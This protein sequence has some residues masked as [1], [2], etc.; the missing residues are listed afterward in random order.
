MHARNLFKALKEIALSEGIV[1]SPQIRTEKLEKILKEALRSRGYFCLFGIVK[2]FRSLMIWKKEKRR[3]FSV[4]LPEKTQKVDV[5]FL[6]QFAELGWLH[7]A[8]FGKYYVG[9]WAKKDALFCVKQAYK[10]NS[11]T[12]KV[13]YL[14][15]EAQHFS[16][17]KLFPKLIQVDLEYR[18]KLAELALTKTPRKFLQKLRCEAKNDIH[19]PHSFAAYKILS[20][21]CEVSSPK[22]IRLDATQLLRRHTEDLKRHGA[23]KVK[24]VLT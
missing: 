13:H 6:D 22:A 18:A 8:T 11:S 1:L 12:F 14:S 10:V 24:S 9:G 20:N 23:K 2:P 19:I 21:I 15:H 4:V 17:Y 5:I 7:Y 3:S 16:D